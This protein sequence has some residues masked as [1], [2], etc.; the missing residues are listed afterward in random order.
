MNTPADGYGD[1]GD[2][3]GFDLND[4]DN[5][6][7]ED[8][9]NV[10]DGWVSPVQGKFFQVGE[11][12]SDILEG[13][14]GDSRAPGHIEAYLERGIGL[15]QGKITYQPIKFLRISLHFVF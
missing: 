5:K 15:A 11:V 6:D 12:T 7:V 2:G 1:H 13:G 8:H 14:V 4:N 10:A 3:Y 9:E